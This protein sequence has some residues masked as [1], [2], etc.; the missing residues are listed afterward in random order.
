MKYYL[1]TPPILQP[2]IQDN[3]SILYTIALTHALT[4]L[5]AQQDENGKGHLVYYISWALIDYEKWYTI[6]EKEC[7][8]LLFTK[9]KLIHY[10]LNVEMHVVLK[11]DPLNNLFPKKNLLGH[12]AMWVM[13]L[14]E[15]DLKFF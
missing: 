15:F 12:L 4:T 6:I 10:L 5:V 13:L 9:I 14:P 1:A 2:T 3:L 7:L 11:F 8:A